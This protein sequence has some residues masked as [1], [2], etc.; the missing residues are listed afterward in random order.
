MNNDKFWE[1]IN[2]SKI[3]SENDT[4]IQIEILVSTIAKLSEDEIYDF[5]RM[6]N[7]Y[8]V[9]SYISELWAAAYIINGG[10]SDDGFDYFRG[11]LILQ[12]RKVYENAL[13]DPQSLAEVINEDEAG[14]IEFED[15]LYVSSDAYKLKTGKDDFYDKVE[16]E[17]YPEIELSWSED[18]GILEEMFPK[19]VKKFW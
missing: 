10:C 15:I 14:E 6:F 12:G 17:E 5:D 16:R 7:R 13:N 11:W 3:K 8:Y 9:D 19:L 1:L 18:E 2:D 4:D